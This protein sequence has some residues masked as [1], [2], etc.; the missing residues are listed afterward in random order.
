MWSNVAVRIRRVNIRNFRCL[1][2][3]ADNACDPDRA[4]P[5]HRNVI[6]KSSSRSGCSALLASLIAR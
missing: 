6:H 3:V 5:H 2:D 1:E 4:D